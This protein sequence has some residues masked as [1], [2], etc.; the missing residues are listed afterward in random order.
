MPPKGG[1][2]SLSDN[3]VTRAVVWM[4]NQSG[5]K[6]KGLRPPPHP[7]QRPWQRL[8]QQGLPSRP[9]RRASL[10]M[11]RRPA[12]RT[13]PNLHDGVFRV[14]RRRPGRGTQ[15]GDKAAW[16]PRIGQGLPTLHEHA[17]K[18]IRAMPPKGG[19]TTLSD[20][21]VSAAV[22]YMVNHSK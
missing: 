5:A 3:E 19:N 10:Q 16:K 15:A 12:N 22:D 9:A 2:L 4:A 8:Q 18:G 17:L 11:L 7:L 14:P 1:N 6:L 21:E 13:A 20:A